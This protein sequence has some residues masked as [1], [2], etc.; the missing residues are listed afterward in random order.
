MPNAADRLID[1]GQQRRD[2]RTKAAMAD[3]EQAII[4]TLFADHSQTVRGLFYQLVSQGV[5][6][7]TEAE[8]KGTVVRLCVRLRREGRLP[9]HWLSDNTRWMRKPTTDVGL[10]AALTRTAECYRRDLWAEQAAYVEVWCEKDALAGILGDVTREY[11]VP[12]MVS[13]GFAS[14]TYLYEA[15]QQIK[16]EDK[17]AFIYYFGDHDPSGLKI[18]QQVERGLRE[19]AP[20]A[21]ITFERVAVTPEQIEF[22][23]LPT[24]PTKTGGT[25]N[26]G[27]KGDSVDLDAIPA[28][29]LRALVRNCIEQHIDQ[30]QLR[31]TKLAED[32]ERTILLTL[33]AQTGRAA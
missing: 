3:I 2:R 5:I 16:A 29:H 14:V 18:P 9:Y 15:A 13:R 30:A 4:T 6:D 27:F 20:G 23:N 10:K 1:L 19:H 21:D 32:S 31:I 8:Y 12:L 28:R 24:R 22:W 7:K 25:H 17:P 33:A 26:R 11:D